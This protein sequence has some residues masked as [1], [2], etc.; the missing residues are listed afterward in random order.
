MIRNWTNFDVDLLEEVGAFVEDVTTGLLV[1]T[2][3]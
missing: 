2:I 1:D 3:L